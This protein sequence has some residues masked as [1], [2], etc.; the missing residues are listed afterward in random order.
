V[1]VPAGTP[2]EIVDLLY[3]E[4]AKTVALPDVKQRF[5]QLGF[6]ALA[7]TPAQFTVQIKQEVETWAKVVRAAN[8]KVE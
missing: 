3:R 5:A 8:I 7:N 6:E 2:Q 1:L 4:I